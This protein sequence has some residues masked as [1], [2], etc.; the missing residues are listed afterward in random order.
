MA[1]YQNFCSSLRSELESEIKVSCSCPN[2]TSDTESYKWFIH[3]YKQDFMQPQPSLNHTTVENKVKDPFNQLTFFSDKCLHFFNS[4][5]VEIEVVNGS[6]KVPKNVQFIHSILSKE[7]LA[8]VELIIGTSIGYSTIKALE[9]QTDDGFE[10]SF[11]RNKAG[12]PLVFGI[13]NIFELKI[14]PSTKCKILVSASR[15]KS[16]LD[17]VRSSGTFTT[18]KKGAVFSVKDGLITENKI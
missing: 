13:F 15:S 7:K 5:Y 2:I 9:V 11:Q 14:V 17:S 8:S 16:I 18:N 3:N 4:S 1:L 10:Y 12:I 6:Y